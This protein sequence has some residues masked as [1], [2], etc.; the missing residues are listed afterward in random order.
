VAAGGDADRIAAARETY[1]ATRGRPCRRHRRTARALAAG[2]APAAAPPP[3]TPDAPS[4]GF[5]SL[6]RP[7]SVAAVEITKGM[8]I[9]EVSQ[10]TG[11]PEECIREFNAQNG[12]SLEDRKLQIG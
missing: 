6:R 5:A 12:N 9:W 10:F 4:P 1:D 7:S 11:V 2:P 8:T 3:T